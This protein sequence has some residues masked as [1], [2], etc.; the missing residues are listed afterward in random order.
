MRIRIRKNKSGIKAN[1]GIQPSV[2]M[3]WIFQIVFPEQL[4]AANETLCPWRRIP[5]TLLPII[6][7]AAID[8]HGL[9]KKLYREFTGQF[10]N[11]LIFF[12]LY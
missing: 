12:L 10:Q 9:T 8:V 4:H 6:E 1:F 5:K 2:S 11:Y 3:G 7:A